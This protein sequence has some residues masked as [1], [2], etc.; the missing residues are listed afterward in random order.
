MIYAR[1]TWTNS[2]SLRRYL[3]ARGFI[4]ITRDNSEKSGIPARSTSP[5]GGNLV[6]GSPPAASLFSMTARCLAYMVGDFIFI[7]LLFS[8]LHK[9]RILLCVSTCSFYVCVSRFAAYDWRFPSCAAAAF[10]QRVIGDVCFVC[11]EPT[12]KVRSGDTVGTTK[13]VTV[14]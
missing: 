12:C 8:V 3:S 7:W 1:V 13:S 14:T 4:Q 9:L 2:A 11:P 5:P 10:L 6:D